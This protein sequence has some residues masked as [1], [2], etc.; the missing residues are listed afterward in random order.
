MTGKRER[1]YDCSCG[2]PGDES[3]VAVRAWT[4]AEAAGHMVE[5]LQAQGAGESGPI[6]VRD[7]RHRVVLRFVPPRSPEMPN[8]GAA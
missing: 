5:A 6:T 2:P 4:P 8:R 1:F 7:S 3:H